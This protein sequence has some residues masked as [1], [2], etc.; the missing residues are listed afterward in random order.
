MTLISLQGWDDWRRIR[1][2]LWSTNQKRASTRRGNSMHGASS[3]A[4]CGEV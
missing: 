3:S 1:G 4:I 2:S